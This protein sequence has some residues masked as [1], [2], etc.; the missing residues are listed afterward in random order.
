M[1]IEVTL[2]GTDVAAH[3]EPRLLLVEWLRGQ[4]LTGT[5][6]GCDT[7]TCG[8]CTVLVNGAAVKSCTMLAVQGSGASVT[9]IEGIGE[10][11][12][13]SAVQRAFMAEHGLQCGFCTPGLVMSVTALLAAN[14][15][16]T[17]ADIEAA[18]EGNLCRCTGYTNILRAVR[19]SAA[20]IR[21][22][23]PVVVAGLAHEHPLATRA[24]LTGPAHEDL[25]DT[26]VV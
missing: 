8:A 16:P 4:G 22:E 23:T 17:P 20:V 18:L 19:H 14:S 11:G 1:R 21:G 25:G 9:T 10:S 2:N 26:E 3:V 12:S 5:H 15:E 13:P 24:V 7:S 6:V